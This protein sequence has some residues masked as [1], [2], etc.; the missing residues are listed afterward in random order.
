[1]TKEKGDG[2]MLKELKMLSLKK[3]LVRVIVFFAVG[4]VFIAMQITSFRTLIGGKK[5]L[6]ELYADQI[7]DA[8]YVE[9]TVWGIYDQ[10][11]E[12]TDYDGGRL[13][14]ISKEYIIPVGESEYMGMLVLPEY[15]DRCDALIDETWEYL[16][17]EKDGIDGIFQVKGTI[18]AM[19]NETLRYFHDALGYDD[20]SL[21]ERELVLPYYLV[22][23]QFGDSGIDELVICAAFCLFM[24]G[25]A[26]WFL[27]SAVSGSCQKGLKKYCQES[28]ALTRVEQFYRNTTPIHGLRINRDYIL[29]MADG[30]SHFLLSDNLIWAYTY[31][32][33]RT[34]YHFITVSKSVSVT[35]F[36]RNGAQYYHGVKNEDQAKEILEYIK[37]VLP[38][39]IVGYSD[40]LAYVYKSDRQ[41]MI[42]TVDERRAQEGGL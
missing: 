19:D 14:A 21:E 6:D 35:F 33:K 13:T 12:T 10:Y 39:A 36:D 23:D 24:W 27:I 1:M 3:N 37:R 32:E 15:Y 31:I 42:R 8:M 41:G 29:G 38:W 4:C 34:R 5:N 25:L 2:A 16:E 7:H 18:L 40:E 30:K 11:A 9:G 28:G 22:V 17:G 20:W 26:L